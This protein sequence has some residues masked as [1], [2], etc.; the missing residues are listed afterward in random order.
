MKH[1]PAASRYPA[2]LMQSDMAAMRHDDNDIDIDI[3]I[4]AIMFLLWRGKYII[5]TSIAIAGILALL[6]ISDL[7]ARYKA[8][9]TV[10]FDIQK[11]NVINLSDVVVEQEFGKD[12]LQNQ[13]QILRS[14]GLIQRV[15]DDQNLSRVAEFN[16]TLRVEKDTIVSRIQ[17]T[18]AV[19][20]ELKNLLM[21]IG[22]VS[23]P[24]TPPT[25][26]VKERRERLAIVENVR[27]G[28][29]LKPILGS[30][31]IEV[32]FTSGNPDLS[33]RIVNAIADQYIVDQLDAKLDATRAATSWLTDRVTE[34]QNRVETSEADVESARAR[35]SL[36]AGQGPDP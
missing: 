14:K 8:S 33:S 1:N 21:D 25:T 7:E 24:P 18:M 6:I 19:P 20:P 29:S 16:P 10:M 31:V 27:A 35:L 34:L 12:T 26:E 13:I 9:A 32:S 2:H 30:R 36:E 3:D 4:R 11:T 23:P 28:L 15:I 22:I 5:L 17:N